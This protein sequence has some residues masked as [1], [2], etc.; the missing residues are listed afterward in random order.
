M[1]GCATAPVYAPHDVVEGCG[2]GG[3]VPVVDRALLDLDGELP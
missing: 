1:Q 3:Q 2:D